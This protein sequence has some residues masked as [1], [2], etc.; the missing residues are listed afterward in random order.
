MKNVIVFGKTGSGKSALGNVL[1]GRYEYDGEDG[2]V[3]SNSKESYTKEPVSKKST[4]RKLKYYDT[5]GSFDTV[6]YKENVGILEG[7]SQIIKDI[8]SIWRTVGSSGLHAILLTLNFSERLSS[9]EAKL[10]EFAGTKL[11][12]GSAKN[13]ILLIMTKAPASM[14][15]SKQSRK[16]WLTRKMKSATNHLHKFYDLVNKDPDPV[17]FIDCKMPQDTPK[18][19]QKIKFEFKKHNVNMAENVLSAIHNMPDDGVTVPVSELLAKEIQV[20][21]AIDNEKNKEN[22]DK[23]KIKQL[24]KVFLC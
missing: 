11:F 7:N 16:E 8:V 4:A 18:E 24:G 2:F 14:W 19:N 1:L 23:S 12:T 13:R 22:P 9:L 5:I 3:V 17:I 10:A 21:A 6:V 20:T 15:Y